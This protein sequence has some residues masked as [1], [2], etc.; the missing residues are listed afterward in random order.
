MQKV[1]PGEG[2]LGAE[3]GGGRQEQAHTS[4]GRNSGSLVGRACGGEGVTFSGIPMLLQS[5]LLCRQ[6]PQGGCTCNAWLCWCELKA[7]GAQE[8][9]MGRVSGPGENVHVSTDSTC[10]KA[11]TY[12]RHCSPDPIHSKGAGFTFANASMMMP[13]SCEEYHAVNEEGLHFSIPEIHEIHSLGLLYEAKLL[14]TGSFSR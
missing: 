14:N 5:F 4:T 6:V 9:G 13:C 10:L 7:Q 12:L 2:A 3:V 1:R 8:V 11:Q